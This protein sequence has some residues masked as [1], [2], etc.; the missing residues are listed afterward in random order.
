M[1]KI[2]LLC[3]IPEDDVEVK[4]EIMINT[5]SS[6]FIDGFADHFSE[7]IKLK[8]STAWLTRFKKYCKHRY[9]RHHELCRR[10]N[11]TLMVIQNSK[12][13]FLVCVQE[14]SFMNETTS[15][16]NENPVKKDSDI[17]SINPV[18]VD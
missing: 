18:V 10:V 5:T 2:K 15:L 4:I 8:R 17:A 6:F 7:W 3:E 16:K 14:S 9:S 1:A 11:L 12:K 13:D